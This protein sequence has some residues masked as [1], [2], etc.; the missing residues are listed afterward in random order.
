MRNLL[1][2]TAMAAG[3]VSGPAPVLGQTPAGGPIPAAGQ[4]LAETIEGILAVPAAQRGLWGI[5]VVDLASG[6][7]VYQ[8][9]AQVPM[10]PASNTKLFSTALALAR[11]GPDFTFRTTVLAAAAPDAAGVVRGDLRL[12]GGGDPTLSG[13]VLPYRKGEKRGDE[14]APLRDLARQVAARGVRRVEGDLVADGTRI[15]W[16]PYPQGWT[17]DDMAWEYGAPVSA[18]VVHDNAFTLSLTAGKAA[19]YPVE[20]TVSPAADYFTIDNRLRVVAGGRREVEIRRRPG[21]RVLQLIGVLPPGAASS[22]SLALD[23]PALY[24]GTVFRRLLAEQGVTVNGRVVTAQREDG[25]PYVAPQGEVLAQRVSPPL[26]ETLTVVNKVS[27][28]LHAEIALLAA[29]GKTRGDWTA[30][31]GLAELDVLLRAAEVA[32]EWYDLQDGSGLSR[33][34]LAAPEVITRLLA[35]LHKSPWREDFYRTLPVGGEDGSLE[36]RFRGMGDVSALR[37][38]TGSV[39]HVNALSGY[40][41]ADPARRY[42]FSIIANHTTASSFEVRG[43]IDR[44]GKALLTERAK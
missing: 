37:A 17:V 13:R 33:R 15:P 40:I 24:A 14:L 39:S 35:W 28:N 18:F 25:E 22:S 34:G 32:P 2:W 8:K 43:L 42:A 31:K 16:A 3:L 5:H 12:V 41:G 44:I 11:L 10:T 27:Q 26:I 36:R 21:S 19:G 29:A 6:E 20:V 23:D 38:K 7:T 1:F 9:N 30:E 4:A